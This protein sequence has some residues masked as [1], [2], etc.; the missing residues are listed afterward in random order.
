MALGLNR[1][2]PADR[3]RIV[4]GGVKPGH[5]RYFGAD[6]K[7]KRLEA[8]DLDWTFGEGT[9]VRGEAQDLLLLVCGRRL[10]PGR[11]S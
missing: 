9:P 5:L 8:T 1:K 7:G 3:L 10:P 4:L 2:V 6:L 11:L